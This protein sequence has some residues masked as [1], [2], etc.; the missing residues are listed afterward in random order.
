MQRNGANGLRISL[1]G[2]FSVA[3]GGV[4]VAPDAWRRRKPA[5]LLKILALTT[6]HRAHREQ[7]MDLLWPELEPAA[8]GANLRKAIHQ[9]RGALDGASHGAGRLIEFQNDILSLASEGLVIDAVS[10]RSALTAARRAG[11]MEGYRTALGWYRGALL[12]EDPYEEWAADPRRE[13]HEEYVAGLS[14]WCSLLEAHGDI[15]GAIE[16]GR[17]LV[18][19]EP[20]R[21]EAHA[22]LM[23]LYGLSGRRGDA[24]RQ[25]DYLSEVLDRELGM[26]PSARVQRLKEEINARSSEE[27]EFTAQLWERVGDLR[28]LAGDGAGAAKAFE[29]AFSADGANG[30]RL[31]RKCAEAWLMQHR[32]DMAAPHLESAQGSPMDAAERGR[33]RRVLAIQAWETGDI[34]A[35][36]KLA[37]EAR[38]IAIECGT[39]DDL[40]AAREAGAI[41]SHFEGQWREGLE[42]ELERMAAAEG[43]GQLSRVFDIHHCIGQYHLYGDGLSDSVEGYARRILD[44]AEEAGAVRAQAFGWCLLGESLL[45]QARWEESDGCLE[46]SCDLH[47][48]LGSR[49]GA[50]A[51]QR[52]AEL[53]ACQ[54]RFDEVTPYLRRASGIATVSP[55]ARHLWGRIHATAAFAAIQRG[56]PA[57]AI[58]SVQAAAGAGARYGECPTCSALLNPVAAEAFATFGDSDN[59]RY[60]SDAARRVAQYFASSAWQAMAESASGSVNALHGDRA[61]ARGH[62][63]EASALYAKAGQPFWAERSARQAV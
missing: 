30:G 53:A 7:V 33:L 25:Y 45:L 61:G 9:A 60:Y 57:S 52:R 44:R 14:E 59:A 39:T 27:P 51:W 6:G 43:D 62:F 15:E 17:T 4:P 12:P 21:E 40:A 19:T 23:R 31:E 32:P 55:M 47:D 54:G 42:S 13:L 22:L 36:R 3:V 2:G 11:D 5:A 26:E 46:R 48:S 1:L 29:H 58:R 34:P 37:E 41:V 35:A 28:V 56:D 16:A 49:S 63:G 24:L 10:F 8:A 18:A 20:T 38:E 50:L